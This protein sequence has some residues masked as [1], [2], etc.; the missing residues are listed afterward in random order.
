MARWINMLAA[1][2]IA[3]RRGLE[4]FTQ[5]SVNSVNLAPIFEADR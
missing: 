3:A 5:D 1:G 4:G 2:A